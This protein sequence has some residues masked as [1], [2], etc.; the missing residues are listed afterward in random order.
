MT[1]DRIVRRGVGLHLKVTAHRGQHV[2]RPA[3]Q[4]RMQRLVL[5]ASEFTRLSVCSA[6]GQEMRRVT[7]ARERVVLAGDPEL[8]EPPEVDGGV[9]NAVIVGADGGMGCRIGRLER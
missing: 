7:G 9:L 6:T 1:C 4:L 3:E 2:E 5:L 8:P